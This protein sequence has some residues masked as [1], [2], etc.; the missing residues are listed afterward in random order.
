MHV[1]VIGA[2]RLGAPYGV[3][4][5]RLGHN[6]LLVDTNPATVEAINAGEAPFGE[7]GL[8]AAI[9]VNVAAGRLRATTSY[10]QATNHSGLHILCVGTPQRPDS[11]AADLRDLRAAFDALLHHTRRTTVILGKSSVPMGTAEDLARRAQATC[12]HLVE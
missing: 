11:P 4:L 7:P 1:C 6:V 8:A 12:R 2:G 9:D 10:I 5:A 3:S